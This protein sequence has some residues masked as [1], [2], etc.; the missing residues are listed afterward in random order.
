MRRKG[1]T[2]RSSAPRVTK[3]NLET[4][5]AVSLH[6]WE[7]PGY[8]PP[9]RIIQLPHSQALRELSSRQVFNRLNKSG[10]H[11]HASI[12]ARGKRRTGELIR[13]AGLLLHDYPMVSWTAFYTHDFSDY[14]FEHDTLHLAFFFEHDLNGFMLAYRAMEEID[15]ILDR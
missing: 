3:P 9:H 8:R 6:P 1:V 14:R 11:F 10:L 5:L 13:A 12:P 2:S 7:A 15:T 4:S